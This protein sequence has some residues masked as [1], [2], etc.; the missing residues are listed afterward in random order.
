MFSFFHRKKQPPVDLSAIVTDMHNHLLP[1][2]DDGSPDAATS[3]VLMEGLQDLGLQKFVASPHIL[4]DLYRNDDTSI[5][6][7][8]N[9]LRAYG[10]AQGQPVPITAAAE[11]MMDDYF[12]TLLSNKAPLR[13]FG[14][15]YVLVEFSFVSQPFEWKEQFFDLQVQGYK[16]VLA[17]PERYAYL[18][19]G[20]APFEEI[21][22]MGV[23]LQVNLNSLTGYYGKPAHQLAQLL[24]KHKMVSF[25]G[26]DL[27]HER[28]LQALQNSK[29]LMSLLQA[30]LDSGLLLNPTL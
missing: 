25:L 14:D 17:H 1:G 8:L 19:T 6:A 20:I 15:R 27:H 22:T 23:L 18:G 9:E 26:T 11:Y 24:I 28:H 13:T 30:V 16:P 7:S 5:T 12:S 3:M 21:R 4:W 29:S 2:I 10:A